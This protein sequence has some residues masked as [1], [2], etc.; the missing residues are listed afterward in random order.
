MQTLDP[1]IAPVLDPFVEGLKSPINEKIGDIESEVV[2]A[3][4]GVAA[5]SLLTGFVLGRLSAR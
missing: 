5:A 3:V 1:I 2:R 4:V